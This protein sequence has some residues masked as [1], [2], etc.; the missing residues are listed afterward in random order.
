MRLQEESLIC[1]DCGTS[2]TV[3]I[4]EQERGSPVGLSS[5]PKRCSWCRAARKIQLNKNVDGPGSYGNRSERQ[6]FLAT[7]SR[8]GKNTQVPFRPRDDKRVYCCDCYDLIRL[9]R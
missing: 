9:R 8:C 1:S 7:C 3:A 6:F 2:F 4:Q 5:E